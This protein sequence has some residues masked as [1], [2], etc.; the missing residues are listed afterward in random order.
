MILLVLGVLLL[1]VAAGLRAG[2]PR[3]APLAR[4]LGIGGPLL[5]VGGIGLSTLAQVEA[6]QIGVVKLFGS[7]NPEV[8]N[9]GLHIINPLATV[10]RFDA[11]TR[12]Y[13][14]SAVHGEGAVVG[15]DAIRALTSD[16]LEV[17]IDVSVLYH[18]VASEAPVLLS[19]IGPD[20]EDVVVRPIARSRI[21][22]ATVYYQAVQLYTEKREEF[23]A[24]IAESITAELAS[25]HITLEGLLIRN[26]SLPDSVKGTIEGKIQAEQESQKMVFVL[27]KERQEAERKR[28]EAQGIADSQRILTESLND[29]LL[30]YEQ[31]KVMRELATSANAKVIVMGGSDTPLILD[32]TAP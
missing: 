16:G 2:D 24:R 26:I 10:V 6:G 7:V 20:Y 19:E 1:L 12:N 28:V 5:I 27:D 3:L 29:R 30:R 23:Q 11:R 17:V 14:M 8:L 15:D 25:R 21:R 13:T 18:V 4:I 31:I 9:P 22:D 32:G